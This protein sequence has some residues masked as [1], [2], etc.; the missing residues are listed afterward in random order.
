M[1]ILD[2][3]ARGQQG[4]VLTPM[5]RLA[6]QT[7]SQAALLACIRRGDDLNARDEKG[8][9]ALMIA[10]SRGHTACC[11]LM[12]AHGAL[13]GASDEIT[14]DV[15]TGVPADHEPIRESGNLQVW[16]DSNPIGTE[17]QRDAAAFSV[18]NEPAAPYVIAE[19]DAWE[20]EEETALP[21]ADAS[22]LKNARALQR[23][24][25]T[26]V[27]IDHD[28]DWADVLI[29]LPAAFRQRRGDFVEPAFV[30]FLGD[31]FLPALSLGCLSPAQLKRL[32][33]GSPEVESVED[34]LL[35]HH[36][37][38]A[39]A[40][41]GVVLD[42][43][44]WQIADPEYSG[45]NDPDVFGGTGLDEVALGISSAITGRDDP[46]WLY[47]REMQKAG[48]LL[49]HEEEIAL[50]QQMDAGLAAAAVD[51]MQDPRTI[52]A[53]LELLRARASREEVAA[54]SADDASTG[55]EGAEK[56]VSQPGDLP[57]DS[58]GIDLGKAL[59][60]ME[61]IF[62]LPP[63][64]EMRQRLV[65]GMFE[66]H[67]DRH[68]LRSLIEVGA[69]R[70]DDVAARSRIAGALR[71]A[72]EA[73]SRLVRSNLRLAWSIARK[74]NYGAMP[75]ADLVQEANTGLMKAA[76]RFDPAKGFRFSTYA[77]WWI[78]QSVSRGIAEHARLI[79]LPV[80]VTEKVRH[81]QKAL[82][83]FGRQPKTSAEHSQVAQIAELTE[84]EYRNTSAVPEDPASLDTD[85][86]C[87][88]QMAAMQDERCDP[89][90]LYEA[91]Q[92]QALAEA[93]LDGLKPKEA[94]ILRMRFGLGVRD[95]YTLEE[96]GRA[97]EVTRERVRQIESKA[98]RQLKRWGERENRASNAAQAR[99][100]EPESQ[101]PPPVPDLPAV[102]V[103]RVPDEPLIKSLRL[104]AS[105]KMQLALAGNVALPNPQRAFAQDWFAAYNPVDPDGLYSANRHAECHA[106]SS[107]LRQV[108]RHHGFGALPIEQLHESPLWRDV[109]SKA[110]AMLI[111]FQSD[112]EG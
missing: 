44:A 70:L 26:H 94:L 15:P 81:L 3:S 93:A 46:F 13:D 40:D 112:I 31:V 28:E 37:A 88:V 32:L 86:A 99:S 78:R 52:S 33:V 59:S 50:G 55:D 14:R 58:E 45:A 29:D 62:L 111:D 53:L 47:A 10:A 21:S 60:E 51:A 104:L 102:D 98:M 30:S 66:F 91:K 105:P 108:L 9:S 25:S 34:E 12:R 49:S 54:K 75:L 79:R 96:I 90:L 106:L 27:A 82:A 87:Q 48:A 43:G 103:P 36:V 76:D 73:R 95:E 4:G 74:Y 23:A 72:H 110:A 5:L 8:R 11:D 1:A 101:D 89:V 65:E 16:G 20:A 7:G 97:L 109:M 41:L 18:L 39:L 35:V 17:T 100:A 83:S 63:S 56:D 6:A 68:S 61:A 2:S 38:I 57:E 64:A 84:R 42:E 92:Q 22:L 24:I 67:L 85:E 77:T 80:H 19:S 69:T 71:Q 107:A